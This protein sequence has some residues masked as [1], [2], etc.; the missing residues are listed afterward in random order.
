MSKTQCPFKTSTLTLWWLGI[1]SG[2]IIYLF[3][4]PS[5]H[6]AMFILLVLVKV[7]LGLIMYSNSWVYAF[8]HFRKY[9][10]GTLSAL[11][12][13]AAVIANWLVKWHWVYQPLWWNYVRV[14]ICKICL[15]PLGLGVRIPPPFCVCGIYTFCPYHVAFLKT[16]KQIDWRL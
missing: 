12:T 1:K 11:P 9:S 13:C 5:M 15:T 14:K 6:A 7:T 8:L 16:C 10:F 3:I 2:L 4:H